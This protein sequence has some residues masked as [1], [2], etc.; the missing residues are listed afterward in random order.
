[1]RRLHLDCPSG[2]AGDMLLASLIDLGAPLEAI[3]SALLG[4]GLEEPWSIRT[5]RV[6]KGGIAALQVTVET[7]APDYES[8]QDRNHEHNHDHVHEHDQ[9]PGDRGHH[10]HDHGHDDDRGGIPH[11]HRPYRAIKAM[12]EGADLPE[13]ARVRALRVFA[14]LAEAEGAVHG[15]P[16]DEVEFHE[17]GSTDAI[18]DIV[19]SCLALELLGVDAVTASP[20]HVGRGFVRSAHGLLPVPAPATLLLLQ[21]AHVYQTDVTGELV[22]PTGA[23]IVAAL[24]E[25]VGPMPPMRIAKVG[26]G[27]GRMNLK[28]PNVLRAILGDDGPPQGAPGAAGAEGLHQGRD[29]VIEFEAN[30]DDLNP[31][32]FPAV[33]ERLFAAGAKDAWVVPATMKK[34]RPGWVLHALGAPENERTLAEIIF[35]ETT[36]LG[37]RVRPARRWT[38]EREWVT[39][40]T[41]GGPVRVKVG[42]FEGRI[43][44]IAPEFED[45]RKAA[46]ASGVP[47]KTMIDT[48]RE[49]ARKE[50]NKR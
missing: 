13:R 16:P 28:I 48:A 7:G 26:C 42:R 34:G 49:T 32:V 6:Y 11:V 37:M 41:E 12:L 10:H 29:N 39:V 30:L 24:C 3:H 25:S 40:A 18:V 22:T 23:A 2:I 33:F 35:A 50:L 21:G 47:L 46:A 20:L 15:V 17:V 43:T 45:C 38:L 36:T 8:A 31:Q 4:L 5:E 27:A 9:S 19:G 1:M 14:R 44:N